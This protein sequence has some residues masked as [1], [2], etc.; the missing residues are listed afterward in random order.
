MKLK[1]NERLHLLT[2]LPSKGNFETLVLGK[3]IQKKIE[4]GPAEVEEFDIKTVG[5]SLTWN[6][7]G[8]ASNV[9]Y[10]FSEGEKNLIVDLLKKASETESLS[11]DLL[12]L[13]AEIVK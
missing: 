2:L 4:I 7:S 12:D 3:S 10:E 11:M 13:Y 6:A 9:E 1:L 5:E 8:V